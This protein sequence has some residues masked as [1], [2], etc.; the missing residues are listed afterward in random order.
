MIAINIL[1]STLLQISDSYF[2]V[3]GPVQGQEYGHAISL[4]FGLLIT[5]FVC[6]LGGAAFLASTLTVEADRKVRS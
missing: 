1:V 5:A 4:E 3:I 2:S 6:V